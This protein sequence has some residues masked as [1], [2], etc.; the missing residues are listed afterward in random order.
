MADEKLLFMTLKL[1]LGGWFIQF[2]LFQLSKP[3]DADCCFS[4]E[5]L[6]EWQPGLPASDV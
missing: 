6:D 5:L 1:W 4:K 3:S 2:T